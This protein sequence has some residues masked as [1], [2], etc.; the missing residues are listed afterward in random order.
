MTETRRTAELKALKSWSDTIPDFVLS[1]ARKCDDLASQRA[2]ADLI[3]YS[4]TTVNQ[5]LGNSYRG[6]MK[7]VEIAIRGILMAETVTCPVLGQITKDVCSNT[8]R[9]P[10]RATNSQRVR[11]YRACRGCEHRLMGG[12]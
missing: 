7:R 4:A 3:G 1:L 9:E 12:C 6:D 5:V 2:V 8:Q 10:F 11:I